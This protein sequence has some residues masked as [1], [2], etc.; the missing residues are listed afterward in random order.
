MGMQSACL[1][2]TY[3]RNDYCYRKNMYKAE[4][5]QFTTLNNMKFL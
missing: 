5:M 3:S 4:N 1:S 2:A